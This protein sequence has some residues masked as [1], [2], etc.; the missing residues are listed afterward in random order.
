MSVE[1][2]FDH[3]LKEFSQ[4]F[5]LVNPLL[6]IDPNLDGGEAIN[7]NHLRRPYK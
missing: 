4:T 2:V 7:K 6:V 1:E 3:K 5:V